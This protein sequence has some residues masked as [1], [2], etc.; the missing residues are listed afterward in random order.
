[1]VAVAVALG[2]GRS[3]P[4]DARSARAADAALDRALR[5]LVEMPGG[6][7]GAIALVQRGASLRVHAFGVAAIGDPGRPRKNDHMR[8]ASV[9]KAF[10][11][12]VALSLVD[13]GLLSLDDTIGRWLPSQPSAWHVVTLRQLLGHTSGLPDF[14]ASQAFREAVAGSLAVAPPPAALLAFVADEPLA[15]T[16]GTQYRYSNSDNVAV[17]LI[18]ESATGTSYEEALGRRVLRP[19]G[20]RRTGLPAGPEVPEPLIHGYDLE[21]DGAFDDVSQLFASG[22][23]WASGGIISTPADLNRFIRG[24][25]G[26]RLFRRAVRAQQRR[27]VPAA[28]SEPTGP[29]MN[30]AGLAVFRYR[31]R[32]GTVLGHTGNTLG[33]TQFAAA[34]GDGTRST[35]V[36]IGLQRTQDSPGWPL[37]VFKALRAA[38]ERAVCA[39]LATGR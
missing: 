1:V 25:V 36:S 32:C 35:T 13:A 26:G 2:L 23:A 29:G 34:T 11:G 19:L 12:A 28:G 38:E 30:S 10:S 17:G 33:F 27:W 14:S 24:Y 20:L 16:P 9:A 18:V 37:A 21:Q 22:W 3:V 15:F 6:P 5:E 31:T 4:A 39:A 7:P 8:I